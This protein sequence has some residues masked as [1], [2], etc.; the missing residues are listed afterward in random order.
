MKVSPEL[1]SRSLC[2]N[3]VNVGSIL[4]TTRRCHISEC[5]SDMRN[6]VNLHVI[7]VQVV[8]LKSFGNLRKVSWIRSSSKKRVSSMS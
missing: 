6:E 7:S 3:D 2:K 1:P 8:G 5:Q 4:R